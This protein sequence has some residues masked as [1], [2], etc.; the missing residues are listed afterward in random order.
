MFG[1]VDRG[2]VPTGGGGHTPAGGRQ[3]RPAGPGERAKPGVCGEKLKFK[4]IELD[5]IKLLVDKGVGLKSKLQEV[6]HL[7]ILFFL[8]LVAW[9]Y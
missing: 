3:P 4:K 2:H 6:K 8:D 5:R 7:Y 1:H 9:S